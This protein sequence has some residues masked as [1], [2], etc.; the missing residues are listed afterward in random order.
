MAAVSRRV[1]LTA[2]ALLQAQSRPSRPNIL[3][4]VADQHRADC[5]GAGGNRA[6]RTPHLDRLARDGACFRNAYSSTPTCTPARAALLTGLAPWHHGMLGYGRVAG[7][8]PVEMPRALADAGYHTIGIG[9]MHYTPQ[10]NPH[11]FETLIL[12]ESGRVESGDFRSD[13]RSWFLSQA[14]HLNPDAT[15]ISWNDHRARTYALPER[16]HPTRW[17]ADTAVNFLNGYERP[18][19]F[20]LKVSFA[21]PHSPYD[22]PERFMRQYA[23]AVL[24]AASVGEWAARYAPRSDAS[25]ELW[26]G[27]LGAAQVRASR[28]GY[29][30]SIGFVDEQIGR[31]VE[32][33]ERRGWLEN[34]L[35]LFAA[36]HGDMTGDH[37]LWRKS[38][39]YEASAR[40][41]MLLRWPKG[42]IAAAR[43]R[44]LE[45]PVEIRDILPTFLDAAGCGREGLDGRSLLAL[46][47]GKAPDWREWIDLEHDVCYSPENHWTALTDGRTKYIFHAYSGEEQLFDL[48]GDRAELHDLAGSPAH[49]SSLRLWRGRMVN[50]LSERGEAWVKGGKLALRPKS[51]PLSPNYLKG[52]A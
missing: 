28:Q 23:D 17:T 16:L 3:L 35:I 40:V 47:D 39:A 27:D 19:P 32:A 43:G 52:G 37:H 31:I 9:K 4:L 51:M 25:N 30:G 48:T 42:L 24:P 5:I 10:R 13:Y 44:T 18:E 22:P 12:D 36:D 14:P 1:F 49:E 29:Y 38:Y 11:G 45:P 8:Y 15:G 21:R 34:T 33:L 20:F 6:I 50:H 7:R 46:A 2:P 26:H 41:P